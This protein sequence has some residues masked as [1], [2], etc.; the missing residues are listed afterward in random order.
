[1]VPASLTEKIPPDPYFSIEH[2]Q[3]TPA[4]HL[5]PFVAPHTAPAC[6]AGLQFQ[7]W[8]PLMPN[9]CTEAKLHNGGKFLSDPIVQSPT[10]IDFKHKHVVRLHLGSMQN[11]GLLKQEAKGTNNVLVSIPMFQVTAKHVCLLRSMEK[12]RLHV[13][14]LGSVCCI[15]K[16]L[17]RKNA[18]EM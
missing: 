11:A 9:K 8:P 6:P 13:S 15:S 16:L 3:D 7:L 14:G 2:D 18:T 12:S 17:R 10:H 1:M 5:R 4:R